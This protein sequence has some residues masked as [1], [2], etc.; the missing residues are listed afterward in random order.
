MNEVQ[1]DVTEDL[2]DICWDNVFK[3]VFTRPIPESRGALSKLLSAI[4][5]REL[6]VTNITANEPPVE[7]LRD[8]QI[9]FDINCTMN[10]G[11]LCNVEMTL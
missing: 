7:S 1:F 8:R 9:R 3:S 2:I 6:T 5:D 10:N 4:I 11:E